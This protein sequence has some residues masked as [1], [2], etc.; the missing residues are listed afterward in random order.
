ML[1]ESQGEVVEELTRM[2]TAS[3][4]SYLPVTPIAHDEITILNVIA[5]IIDVMMDI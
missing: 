2:A 4:G 3:V 5:N 1:D